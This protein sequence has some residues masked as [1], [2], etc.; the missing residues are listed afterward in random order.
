MKHSK[1]ILEKIKALND[2]R[3]FSYV[4][5]DFQDEAQTIKYMASIDF[6]ITFLQ[7]EF[8]AA[9]LEEKGE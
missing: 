6:L 1:Q 4:N 2:L 7:E 9:E 5:I 3:V 8:K